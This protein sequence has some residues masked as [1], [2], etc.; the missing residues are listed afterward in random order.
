MA[1]APLLFGGEMMMVNANDD[2]EHDG[3]GC[4]HCAIHVTIRRWLQARDQLA[5]ARNGDVGFNEQDLHTITE[6]L[7]QV[8][9][10]VLAKATDPYQRAALITSHGGTF[11]YFM[12]VALANNMRDAMA[13]AGGEGGPTPPDRGSLN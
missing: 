3:G 1:S 11:N 4:L 12:A 6:R 8:T 5:G 13:A 2:H 10:E 7:A 9:G